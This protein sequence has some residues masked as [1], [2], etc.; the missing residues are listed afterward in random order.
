MSR[1]W[2]ITRYPI[3]KSG[4]NRSLALPEDARSL[5]VPEANQKS[6]HL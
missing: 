6:H 1:F 4:L 5:V 3:N 2:A